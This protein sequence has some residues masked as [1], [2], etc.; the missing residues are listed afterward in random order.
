[1]ESSSFTAERS[2]EMTL[3]DLAARAASL[4]RFFEIADFFLELEQLQ[5][6]VTRV[7]DRKQD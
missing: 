4:R 7:E 5:L 6:L 3:E 2:L 1:L